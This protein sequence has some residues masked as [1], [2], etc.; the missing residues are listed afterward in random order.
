MFGPT[1]LNRFDL[2]HLLVRQ[3]LDYGKGE[4]ASTKPERDFIYVEDAAHAVIKL[5]ETD[6]T[7]ILN[8]GTVSK[9]PYVKL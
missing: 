1:R 6:Y 3:L 9:L 5:L 8:L 7:G 4:V 2:I